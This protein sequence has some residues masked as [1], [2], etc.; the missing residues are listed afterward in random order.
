VYLK[1]KSDF[2]HRFYNR[3]GESFLRGTKW[4]FYYKILRFALKRLMQVAK[5]S[6]FWHKQKCLPRDVQGFVCN[7][8][9]RLDY[10][11]L[12]RDAVYTDTNTK[13]SEETAA[14]PYRIN[15]DSYSSLQQEEI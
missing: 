2:I 1:T 14:S 4:V 3:D 9:L 11:L 6:P 10:C 7:C 15:K 12:L 5:H 13:A 8:M